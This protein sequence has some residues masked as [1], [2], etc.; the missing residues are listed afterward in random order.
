MN[1]D[2]IKGT[3]PDMVCTDKIVSSGGQEHAKSE[4]LKAIQENLKPLTTIKYTYRMIHQIMGESSHNVIAQH[5]AIVEQERFR[6][7][8]RFPLFM[9]MQRNKRYQAIFNGTPY[10]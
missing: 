9:A 6:A 2:Q 8:P 10:Q 4:Q 1:H 5:A 7:D 3:T